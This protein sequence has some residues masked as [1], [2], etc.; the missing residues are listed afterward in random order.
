MTNELDKGGAKQNDR[1]EEL[2]R[3][4]TASN[5]ECANSD[6]AYLIDKT[7]S[8]GTGGIDVSGVYRGAGHTGIT[9]TPSLSMPKKKKKG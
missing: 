8:R 4:D 1:G 5:S 3:V 9:I 7:L 2:E 6:V